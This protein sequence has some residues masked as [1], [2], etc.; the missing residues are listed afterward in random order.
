MMSAGIYER[1]NAIAYHSYI[2]PR[3]AALSAGL[4]ID[5]IGYGPAEAWSSM[6]RNYDD[7]YSEQTRR[8][9]ELG[10]A[11]HMA[12]LE[13][14]RVPSDIVLIDAA[15][16]KG[17]A[18]REARD[19]ARSH[20]LIPLLPKEYDTLTPAVAALRNRIDGIPFRTAP[21][22]VFQEGAIAEASVVAEADGVWLK[23]RPDWLIMGHDEDLIID[24]KTTACRGG[25]IS[26]L[27][28][29][30]R[31]DMRAAFYMRCYTLA[32]GRP[33]RYRYLVQQN[34]WPFMARFHDL[35]AE[36]LDIAMGDVDAAIATWRDC[37]RENNWPSGVENA[38]TLDI[39]G[40]LV[41]N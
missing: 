27:S 32:T 25:D 34:R 35:A 28:R 4:A 5:L 17:K 24:Y 22:G 2:W 14:D 12:V 21:D 38:L 29:W 40:F 11:F 18:A 33:V 23:S 7:L 15:D 36:D 6:M 8:R 39:W 9:L 31:W 26:R 16:Y 10:T 19:I 20:G 41:R 3:E 30:L 13:P 37:V 1:V